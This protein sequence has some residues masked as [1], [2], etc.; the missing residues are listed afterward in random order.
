VSPLTP[1]HSNREMYLLVDK[2]GNLLYLIRQEPSD[3]SKIHL[4][5]DLAD[6]SVERLRALLRREAGQ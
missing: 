2:L 5:L 6:Q 1:D 3:F 4:Y